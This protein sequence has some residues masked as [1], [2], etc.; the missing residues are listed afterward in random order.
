M[1]P[2][3]LVAIAVLC[4]LAITAVPVDDVA[5]VGTAEAVLCEPENVKCHQ[6]QVECLVDLAT[7]LGG[8]CPL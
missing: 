7:N 8:A 6:R 3:K 1:I 4:A 5:V 2:T